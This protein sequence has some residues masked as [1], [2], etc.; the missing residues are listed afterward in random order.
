MNA[1]WGYAFKLAIA[2]IGVVSLVGLIAPLLIVAR[3]PDYPGPAD[4]ELC[5]T[6]VISAIRFLNSID[7][8]GRRLY[9]I[10]QYEISCRQRTNTGLAYFA[11]AADLGDLQANY[12]L[13]MLLTNP[14]DAKDS[15]EGKRRLLFAA[16]G[17]HTFAAKALVTS[18]KEN[19]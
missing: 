7:P 19:D 5:L 13:G 17:G 15:E 16:R 9:A 11:R 10:G 4:K 18:E 6:P 1:P 12:H 3:L 2:L 8:N 14:K